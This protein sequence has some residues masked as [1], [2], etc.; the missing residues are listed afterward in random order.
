MVKVAIGVGK[1]G[2]FPRGAGG[3]SIG[4]GRG[5]RT[6]NTASGSAL[7]SVFSASRGTRFASDVLTRPDGLARVPP[8][9]RF[10]RAAPLG[11]ALRALPLPLPAALPPARSAR[12]AFVL[13]DAAIPRNSDLTLLSAP[14]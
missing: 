4:A 10:A 7:S 11:A 3:T 14:L 2:G 8:A 12:P 5:N 1:G 9:G 13:F 6:S